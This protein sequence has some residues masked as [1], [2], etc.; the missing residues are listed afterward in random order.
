MSTN[1]KPFFFDSTLRDGN[2]ALRKPWNLQEKEFVFNLL[3][4]LGIQAI[5]VGYAGS[6]D[7]E[8]ETCKHLSSIA[9][10]NTMVCS[11]AR[12][13]EIVAIPI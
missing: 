8:F 11:L 2:Q 10:E 7:M 4:K 5:E 9:N 1:R 6:C 3:M 12:T 13:V